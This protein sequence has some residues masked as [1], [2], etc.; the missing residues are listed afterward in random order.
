MMFDGM[1]VPL[2]GIF[3]GYVCKYV[4]YWEMVGIV[5]GI[6]AIIGSWIFI[7]ESP[8]WQLKMGYVTQAQLTLTKISKMNGADCEQDIAALETIRTRLNLTDTSEMAQIPE[9]EQELLGTTSEKKE[10]STLYFLKQPVIFK[11]L[12]VMSYL[13]A[14]C[15]FTYYMIAIY[16]KYL[17]GSIF[18][19]T[20]ASGFSEMI[21]YVAGGVIYARLGIKKTI[22]ILFTGSAAGGL[23]IMFL[24]G[25]S[26]LVISVFVIIAKF[27]IS[28][29]FT[30]LYVCNGEVF[31]TMFAASALGITN[32][33]SRFITIFSAEIAEVQPPIPM[34]LFTSLSLLGAFLVWF[35]KTNDEKTKE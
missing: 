3:F 24:S 7:P 29:V 1:S 26:D 16:V 18:V 9:D 20:M 10:E 31:P 27:G 23:M 21:A 28:G 34:I 12:M 30:I 22:T 35:L 33:T 8:L 13:W 15:S 17:P 19:N 4:I 6:L 32:F 11:N 2:S 5:I 14:A 25:Q